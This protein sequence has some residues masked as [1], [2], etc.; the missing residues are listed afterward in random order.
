[1]PSTGKRLLN[2]HMSTGGR[3]CA[4]N[5]C[6]RVP[7]ALQ[8]HALFEKDRKSIRLADSFIIAFYGFV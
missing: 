1:M 4:L 2:Q 7:A 3:I 6:C 5:Q 8:S